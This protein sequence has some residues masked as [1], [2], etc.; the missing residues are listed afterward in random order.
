MV[1]TPTSRRTKL[2]WSAMGL[3]GV[4]VLNIIRLLIVVAT[5]YFYGWNFGQEVHQVI[6]YVLFLSWIG[7]F[8][9]TFFKRHTI[10][11]KIRSLRQRISTPL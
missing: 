2:L 6:G 3:I 7:I 11:S 1:E 8:F 9:F 5:M 4:F 10:L